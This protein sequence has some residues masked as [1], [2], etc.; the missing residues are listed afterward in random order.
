MTQMINSVLKQCKKIVRW[1]GLALCLLIIGMVILVFVGRQTIEQLD[2]IRPSITSFIAS[3]TGFQVNLGTLK[4]EWPQLIPVIDAETFE[5]IDSD[6]STVLRLDG[7]RADLDLFSSL[8]LGSLIW[9]DLAIDQLEINFIENASGHWRLKGFNGDSDT[10]LNIILEPFLY[11]HKIRLKAVTINLHSF[12]GQKTQLFGH[13]MIIENDKEFHRAQLSVSVTEDENPAHLV[14]EALGNLSDLQSFKA[15]G[16]LKF[17]QLDISESIKILT[18]TLMPDVATQLDQYPILAG[19]QIW[20]DFS[21]GWHLDRK[22]V[23]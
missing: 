21:P 7:A 23:V 11:S 10:D 16:Y 1:L 4:G 17:D 8:K 19:G 6:Q 13:E 18:T 20:L 3:S 14:V 9:R 22:S 12:S 5:L 2:E 15:S